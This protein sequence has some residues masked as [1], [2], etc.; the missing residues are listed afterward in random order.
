MTF[1]NNITAGSDGSEITH[2]T[3]AAVIDVSNDTPTCTRVS[4]G[5]FGANNG[6]PNYG[7][8]GLVVGHTDDYI[9]VYGNGINSDTGNIYV[10]RVLR[11]NATTRS[12][13]TFYNG[14][15][16]GNQGSAT[17]VITSANGGTI[18]YNVHLGGYLYFDSCEL[19]QCA[20]DT[21][22]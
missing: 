1:F 16:W 5:W 12:E 22:S 14:N 8:A 4:N 19:S 21:R 17:P 18:S 11:E 3:G 10:A 13:Y 2:N 9:Y 15:G 6:V 20:H 7:N